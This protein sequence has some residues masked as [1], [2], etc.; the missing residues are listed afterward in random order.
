M[1][2]AVLSL[3]IAGLALGAILAI[4]AKKFAVEVDERVPKIRE[5]LPGANCGACG[6][7]G[8]DGLAAAIVAGSAPVNACPVGGN[9]V[10]E[11]IAAIM[12]VEAGSTGEPKVAKVICQGDQ[13]NAVFR[14]EYDGP[15]SC[16]A[17]TMLGGGPKGCSYA[18]VG[19]GTCAQV[20][21][22]GAITMSDKGLPVIDGELCTACGKCVEACP[23]KV[24]ELVNRSQPVWIL[25]NSQAK[26][27]EVRKVCKVGCIAC[28]ICAKVCPVDA[29]EVKNNLAKIDPA[30]CIKCG[31]C[32]QKC[33]MHTI[34][35]HVKGEDKKKANITDEC[36]GC[37][38]CAK[39]CPVQ[40]ISG[41]VKQKHVVDQEKCIGCELCVQKCPKKAINMQ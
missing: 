10:A 38:L 3:A 2:A 6:Y 37:T 23:K 14:S 41:E 24:I 36:I 5:V 32:A 21:P 1:V 16:K 27:A 28:G 25:C 17:A 4:A 8:C 33:P 11:Q 39:N 35:S 20:C 34:E 15:M 26:G 13:S 19:L 18:C 29:I 9:P 12:G 30:K 22:F 40:A 7:P 31:L